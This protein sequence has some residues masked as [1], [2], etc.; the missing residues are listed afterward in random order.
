MT[1]P[2][3]WHRLDCASI[4]R[5]DLDHGKCVCAEEFE[6]IRQ[7]SIRTTKCAEP[8]CANKSYPGRLVCGQ[9]E[10]G[11][12]LSR[13]AQL[14]EV[15]QEKEQEHF[16]A[17]IEFDERKQA[18]ADRDRFTAEAAELKRS[19][20]NCREH[21]AEA[22]QE[23]EAAH[24]ATDKLQAMIDGRLPTP[25]EIELPRVREKYETT[26][27][28]ANELYA[29]VRALRQKNETLREEVDTETQ[30]WQ[31][32]LRMRQEAV[33]A[34]VHSVADQKRE[35]AQCTK[36]IEDVRE[37]LAVACIERDQAIEE[38]AECV[39]EIHRLTKLV[40][41]TDQPW[42]EANQALDERRRKAEDE[43][44][45]LEERRIH[46]EAQWLAA[47]K[48]LEARAREAESQLRVA[49][50][51]IKNQFADN[52]DKAEKIS[53]LERKLAESQDKLVDALFTASVIS[54]KASGGR[55]LWPKSDVVR[56]RKVIK[57]LGRMLARQF[58]WSRS[59]F[60]LEYRPTALIKHVRKELVEIEAKPTD[61]VEWV[62]VAL[63]ALDA[64]WRSA[65]LSGEMLATLII[66]KMNTNRAR[67]WSEPDADG[68]VQHV[69]EAAPTVPQGVDPSEP[70]DHNFEP[71]LPS[72]MCAKCGHPPAHHPPNKP[73]VKLD[74]DP[75]G[76][77]GL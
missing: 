43:V 72:L 22:K 73:A 76:G 71:T 21:L 16:R 63:L 67:K 40:H 42:R 57:H 30:R 28:R 10:C 6:K 14:A 25:A 74:S 11:T 18:E 17:G 39:A 45:V 70:N 66:T 9:A 20:D 54:A 44:K 24:A 62:D 26:S 31:N 41:D 12:H 29:E 23:T 37:T 8:G 50:Q 75:R 5:V 34:C 2:G 68:C 47:N 48:A 15:I 46:V 33:T 77:I 60:G 32:E 61:P 35:R 1:A 56:E 3:H 59:T 49:A 36:R 55:A 19:L 52:V 53:N 65:R 69:R 58:E 4:R 64:A 7:G 27:R 51:D 38:K 13:S